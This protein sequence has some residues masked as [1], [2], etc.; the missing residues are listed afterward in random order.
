MKIALDIGHNCKHDGG[1]VGIRSENALT[2]ELGEKVRLLL[3]RAGHQVIEVHPVSPKSLIDSLRQRVV[4]ANYS[5]ADLFVSL[6][7]NAFYGRAHGSEVLALSSKAK[8]IGRRVLTE[9][10]KLGFYDRGVKSQ[11]LYVLKY[12]MMPAILIEGCFCD[13]SRD[14]NLYDA[15]NMARA[16]VNGITGKD[17]TYLPKAKLQYLKITSNTWIKSSTEQASMLSASEI[18]PI[19]PGL[20]TLERVEP[21]EEHHFW[22]ELK[23]GLEGFIYTGHAEIENK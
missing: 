11:N 9:I 19:A 17:G 20:Y 14:M 7:F 22:V 18:T 8:L 21:S 13:S 10:C 15:D 6:H 2:R 3:Q 5:K 4:K 23:S 16:I 1:A 12:T